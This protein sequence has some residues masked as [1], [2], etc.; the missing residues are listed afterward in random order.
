LAQCQKGL[1]QCIRIERVNQK[2]ALGLGLHP[3]TTRRRHNHRQTKLGGLVGRKR[4]AFFEGGQRKDV[5]FDQVLYDFGCK[6]DRLDI[7]FGEDIGIK[8]IDGRFNL[9]DQSQEIVLWHVAPKI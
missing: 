8:R 2:T 3:P 7:G 5:R 1:A 9:S 4:V 6:P